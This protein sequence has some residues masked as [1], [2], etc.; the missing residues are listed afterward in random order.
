MAQTHT[1]VQ[2]E[3]VAGIAARY[4]FSDYRTIWDHPNNAPLKDRRQNP[5]VLFPGD[6]LFIPD[7]ET[8]EYQRPTDK[9]HR[10]VRRQTALRLR[11]I[12][13]DEYERLIANARCLLVVDNESR[14]VTSGADG[15]IEQEIPFS[16]SHCVLIIQDA[17]QTPHSGISIPIRIGHLDPVDEVSGQQGRLRGLGYFTG[18]IDG[19]P[20]PDFRMAV[21]EFQCE[22]DLAVDGIC[23]KATQA[24]LK[25]VFGS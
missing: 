14:Q 25:Q 1:V 3:H 5:N 4:G 9:R 7:R 6:S 17:S 18:E 2:G 21:E 13:Q 24:K 8:A 16:A 20:G 11:V 22:H 15:K 12:L 19:K 23:G 10:F